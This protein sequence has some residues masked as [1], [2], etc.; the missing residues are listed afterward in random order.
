[1]RHICKARL[2]RMDVTCMSGAPYTYR[3]CAL[4][5]Q[6]VHLTPTD[7]AP[8]TDV[9][10]MSGALHGDV[11]Q[12]RLTS[13]DC[14][15]YTDERDLHITRAIHLQTRALHLQTCA[16]H[17][18]TWRM[19]LTLTCAPYTYGHYVRLTRTDIMWGDMYVKPALHLHTRPVCQAHFTPTDLTYMSGAPYT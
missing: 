10:C 14:A 6:N 11:C 16:L 13:I 5:L 2:T 8:Y 15:P 4:H 9:T 12:A 19:R 17:V 7:C 1:M 3:L 18:R